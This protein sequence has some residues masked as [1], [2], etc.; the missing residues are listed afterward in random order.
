[1]ITG[2]DFFSHAYVALEQLSCSTHYALEISRRS[3]LSYGLLTV[4]EVANPIPGAVFMGVVF[5]IHKLMETFF[6]KGKAAKVPELIGVIGG[7]WVY[8]V[9]MADLGWDSLIAKSHWQAL[10]IFS[11][12]LYL[13]DGLRMAFGKSSYYKQMFQEGARATYEYLKAQSWCPEGV[14]DFSEKVSRVF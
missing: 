13:E 12:V 2:V 5:A 7:V 9:I 11:V 4:I 14:K 8:R 3:I 6:F 10:T 1:M